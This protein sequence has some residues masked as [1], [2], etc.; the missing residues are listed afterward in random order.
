[1]KVSVTILALVAIFIGGC[2]GVGAQKELLTVDFQEGQTLRYKFVSSRDISINWGQAKGK[3]KSSKER[4]DKSSESVT[5]IVAYHPV[6][7]DPYGLTTIKATC[8]SVKTKHS[9]KKAKRASKK[10]AV[11]SVA[12][13]SFNFTVNALGKIQ[14]KSQLE[15]LI[16]EAGKKA[17]RTKGKSRIKEPDTIS[18]FTATQWFLWDS[19][20]SLDP[21]HAIDGIAVG[22]TWESVLSI[23]SSIVWSKAR[24]VNYQFE[25][26]RETE[27]ARIAVISSSYS[28]GE[29]VPNKWPL[30][31]S[32]SFRM[33][34]MF[35]FLS[36]YK[37]LKLQGQGTE[38]F[39]IDLGRIEEYEQ[40]YTLETEA[41]FPMAIDV[42]PVITIEQ[43]ITMKLLKD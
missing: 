4:I 36:G 12:G 43:K 33:S 19:I 3:S 11:E 7:V 2:N 5:M 6:S 28:S 8:E 27:E 26:I 30:P 20:S 38:L 42:N 40:N 39:N 37:I 29:S 32:G 1:M 31:Y 34:G 13:K 25:D 24:A 17:F 23:P 22:Q 41:S 35:G 15:E 16:K 18:D 21:D 9:S 14:D 10:D